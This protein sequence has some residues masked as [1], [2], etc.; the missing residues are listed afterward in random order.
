M[1]NQFPDA[2]FDVCIEEDSVLS[3]KPMIFIKIAYNCRCYMECHRN[4]EFIKVTST[5][6]SIMTSDAIRAMIDHGFEPECDHVFL[7]FFEK[8]SDVQFLACFGS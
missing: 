8:K 6:G 7:E 5:S 2:K 1:E 3:T 4:S